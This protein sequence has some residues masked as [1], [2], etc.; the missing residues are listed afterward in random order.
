MGGLRRHE[1]LGPLAQRLG[2]RQR[3]QLRGRGIGHGPQQRRDRGLQLVRPRAVARP[4]TTIERREQPMTLGDPLGQ[5]P[6]LPA[7]REDHQHCRLATSVLRLM[8]RRAGDR[9]SRSSSTRAIV[10]VRRAT[11]SC[12]GAA[13][14][15]GRSPTLGVPFHLARWDARGGV[16]PSRPHHAARR[17]DPT[18]ALPHGQVARPALTCTHGWAVVIS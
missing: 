6:E 15:H 3:D 1:I 13:R 9:R 14:T 17:S 7:P 5:V 11:A 2:S 12:S 18:A 4:S 8:P 16:G 10:Q